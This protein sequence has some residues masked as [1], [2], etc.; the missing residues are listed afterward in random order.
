[1]FQVYAYTDAIN[2][3]QSVLTFCVT[4]NS[5][6]S[7]ICWLSELM[8]HLIVAG[9]KLKLEN[10]IYFI[11]TSVLQGPVNVCNNTSYFFLILMSTLGLVRDSDTGLAV[12]LLVVVWWHSGVLAGCD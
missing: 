6:P 12:D 7:I 3:G 10:M 1:M 11:P 2:A 4:V 8:S 9:T 5:I